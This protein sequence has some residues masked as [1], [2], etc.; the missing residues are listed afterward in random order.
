M[1]APQLVGN[2]T[3]GLMSC[4]PYSFL[5]M[6]DDMLFFNLKIYKSVLVY[7]IIIRVIGLWAGGRPARVDLHG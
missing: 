6:V 7:A 2:Q 5:Y 4:V 3:T 1:P